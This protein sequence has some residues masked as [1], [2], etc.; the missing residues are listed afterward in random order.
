MKKT[1]IFGLFLKE[2]WRTNKLQFLYLILTSIFASGQALLVIY[3]SKMLI[4]NVFTLDLKSFA[5]SLG[6]LLLGKLSLSLLTNLFTKKNKEATLKTEKL[7]NK[8]LSDKIMNLE[9]SLLEDPKVLDLRERAAFPITSIRI[10]ESF[11]GYIGKIVTGLLTLFGVVVLIAMQSI[12]LLGLIILVI[13]AGIIF[14][15]KMQNSIKKQQESI[16][17]WNRVTNYLFSI[18]MND[19]EQKNHR[20][21]NTSKLVID[22]TFEAMQPMFEGLNRIYRSV[23]GLSISRNIASTIAQSLALGYGAIR[24]LS[25][26]FGP[27]IS[28]GDFSVIISS[29]EKFTN[30][31]GEVVFYF[32]EILVNIDYLQPWGEFM[33]LP[34]QKLEGKDKNMGPLETLEFRNVTFKYPNTDKVILDNISFSINKGEKISIVGINNAGKST[35]VKLIMRFFKPD[36]GQI[37]WN[38]IDI[39]TLDNETY[40]KNISGVFQDF[41]LFPFSIYENLLIDQSGEQ[42]VWDSLE[43]VGL[44]KRVEALPNGVHTNLDK[45]LDE[46]ATNFSGGEN[47]KLAIARAINKEASLLIL[48]EPTAALDPIAESEIFEHFSQLVEQKTSIYISH[49][50]SSST[51]C[52]KVLVID[53]AKIAA[54]DS[55]KELMKTENKYSELFNVQAQNYI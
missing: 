3:L 43:K 15:V 8:S 51:F 40:L 23:A 49:R 53:E 41:K 30:A 9:Y 52:D 44:K 36:S 34:D 14:S 46:N 24:V 2:V 22:K 50:M 45:S 39:S 16:I 35:M 20:I 7:M 32:N 10:I 12:I 19:G 18:A 13:I 55:H 54:F 48:D 26:T 4:D 38:G 5:I 27:S 37:L 47:Q 28:I 6:L 17:P 25:T 42:K 1:K 31:M 21:Y 11:V 33:M 29:T